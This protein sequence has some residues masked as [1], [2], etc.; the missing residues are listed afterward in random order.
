MLRSL[1]VIT[2]E[3]AA[4]LVSLRDAGASGVE[5]WDRLETA[6]SKFNGAMADTEETGNGMIGA[7]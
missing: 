4:E 2:P 1:G 7:I 6:I 5:I 3:V